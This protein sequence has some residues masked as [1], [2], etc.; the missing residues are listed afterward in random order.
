MIDILE[1]T[2]GFR[3]KSPYRF[4]EWTCRRLHV[5]GEE[6]H[7]RGLSLSPFRLRKETDTFFEKSWVFEA[8]DNDR[9]SQKSVEP[10]TI[11]TSNS[12]NNTGSTNTF[13][14][15]LRAPFC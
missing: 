8:Q 3:L 5:E 6:D 9:P 1:I 12:P 7:Q 15:A 10:D 14:F 13:L 11:L 4:R 2:Y